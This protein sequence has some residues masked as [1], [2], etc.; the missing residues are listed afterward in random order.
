QV[1]HGN[2]L[3]P[4]TMTQN[5]KFDPNGP[6]TADSGIFGLSFTEKE[7]K[8]VLLPVP[9]EATTSYGGGTSK[10]PQAILK[11]SHQI[12]LFDKDLGNFYE[13]G[14]SMLKPSRD[15]GKLN[16]E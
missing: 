15:L 8:L 3:W 7:S 4:Q 9:W 11:A 16:T 14:I 2:L 12:D 10:G 5:V 6:A 1:F 13:A